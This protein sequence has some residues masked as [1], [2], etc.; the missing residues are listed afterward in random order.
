[1]SDKREFPEGMVPLGESEFSFRCHP[2]VDCFTF[3]CK[4][5]DLDLYPYDVIRLKKELAIDSESFLRDYTE[6]KKG[7][8]PFFPTLKLKLVPYGEEQACPFLSESGCTVYRNR[9]T[10]CRTYPLERAV[11]R[12]AAGGRPEEFY[13]LTNHNYCHG[14]REPDLTSVRKWVRS[15]RLD[16]FNLMNDLWAE[17]DTLF[18]SNPWRG[19]GAGGSRQQMAFMSCY[20]I[21][22]FRSFVDENGVLSQF[23]IDRDWRNRMKRDDGELLKFAFEWIKQVL[24]GRSSLVS[25]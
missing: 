9:P 13:F 14:H 10:S 4:N 20:N 15:Q 21:D 3:C 19:E 11:D 12:S 1:M 8:N 25:K 7:G 18:A 24:G 6:L 2:G 16:E 17:V 5:V 22:G 23:V